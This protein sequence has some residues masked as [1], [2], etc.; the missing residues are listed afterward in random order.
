MIDRQPEVQWS[1]LWERI[2]ARG[3]A[4][5]TAAFIQAPLIAVG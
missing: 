1:V 2:E 4:H 3:D 5:Q